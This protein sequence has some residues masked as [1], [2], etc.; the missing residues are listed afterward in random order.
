LWLTHVTTNEKRNKMGV[1]LQLDDVFELAKACFLASGCDEANAR[2]VARTVTNAERDQCLSHGLFRVPGYCSSIASGVANGKGR[3]TVETLAP[4]LLQVDGDGAMAPLAIQIAQETLV[5]VAKAQGIAAV[6]I[7]DVLHLSA[8][9]P[10]VEPLA[11]QGLVAMACCVAGPYVAPAGGTKPLF[12]TNPFSFAWP[13]PDGPPMVFD[14]ASSAMARGE[15]QIAMREGHDVPPGT[16]VDKEGNPTTDPAAI[17]EGAQLTFGGYKGASIAL[18]VELLAGALV[19]GK[20]SYETTVQTHGGPT[21]GRHSEIIIAIDPAGFG[22][23]DY[24]SRGE[25]LFAKIL[26]QDGTRLPGGRRFKARV[27]TASEGVEVADTLYESLL[28]LKG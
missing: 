17:L 4:G 22:G 24:R 25:E 16:G 11:E 7:H 28:E 26:E 13:R 27:A 21:L 9:W 2:A 10:E 23:G 6:A 3:P 19:G 18:M 8:L 1:R 14:Q 15:V 12:G 5:P 20:F